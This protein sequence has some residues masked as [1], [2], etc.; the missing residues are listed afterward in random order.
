MP[1]DLQSGELV[2]NGKGIIRIISPHGNSGA[3]TAVMQESDEITVISTNQDDSVKEFMGIKRIPMK[4]I[5]G[6]E[7]ADK[8]GCAGHLG[9]V[10]I[11]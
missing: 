4:D 1:L 2:K 3:A 10:E 9:N 6:A 5:D 11:K 8:I 7:T